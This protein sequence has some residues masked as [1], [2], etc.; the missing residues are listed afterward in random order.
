MPDKDINIRVQ[1]QGADQAKRDIDKVAAST[2]D[3]GEKTTEGQKQ[4][5]HSTEQ[6]TQKIG[7]MGKVAGEAKTALMSMFGAWIGAQALIKVV[8]W[9]VD[10]LEA[11][12][13]LQKEITEK[14]TSLSEVGQALVM[15]AGTPGQADFWTKEAL[16][17]QKAGGLKDVGVGKQMLISGDIAF[18]AQG[19]MK[20]E[21]VR[22]LLAKIAPFAG[23]NLLGEEEVGKLFEFAG[24][25]GVAPNE[26]AWMGYLSKLQATYTASK[27]QKFGAFI[28]GLQKGATGYMGLGGS[29]EGALAAFASARAITTNEALAASLL[30]QVT[31]LSSGGYEKPRKAIEAGLGLK[32]ED[33]N[34]DQRV[35]A[36]LQYARGIPENMRMQRLVEMG[37]EPGLAGEIGKMV[38]PEAI[39]TFAAT[40]Q[41]ISQATPELI[42]RQVEAYKKSRLGKTR[43]IE[44]EIEKEYIEAAPG[45]EAWQLRLKEAKGK[46]KVLQTKS[47]DKWLI[48]DKWETE[49]L[50]V[51]AISEDLNELEKTATTPEQLDEIA[52]LNMRLTIHSGPF[53]V[54]PK[55]MAAIAREVE[56]M[57]NQAPVVI[58]NNND[59]SMNY[60][61]AVEPNEVG[62]YTANEE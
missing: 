44:A 22:A 4:A 28:E 27:A 23:A 16:R 62:R 26:Q 56:E 58:N 31:R 18:G 15:Q 3:L 8:N 51:K 9:L 6:A 55:H 52:A 35:G 14:A 11:I 45:F 20:N 36:L 13:Q 39:Q 41:K 17:L 12:K 1:A 60:Y 5:A 40:A 21:Q 33:L 48:P 53:T 54:H 50:A 24:T 47:E 57:K 43:A 38:T 59:Y 42:D 49:L 37:F 2:K 7:I 10:R 46:F 19:G 34:M 61:P 32:W 30:E 29:F 25:A